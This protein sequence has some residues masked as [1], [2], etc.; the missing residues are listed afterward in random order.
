MSHA[1]EV[2]RILA[3]TLEAH[4]LDA[5]TLLYRETLADF[6]QRD[7]ATGEWS[8]SANPDPSEAVVDLYGGGYGVVASQLGPG[9]SFSLRPD[10]DWREEGRVTIAVR[11]G[12]V[13]QQGGLPYPV[14]TVITEPVWYLTLPSGQVRAERV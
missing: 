9:L 2:A 11:L 13:I 3:E 5:E 7:G 10:N 4:G 12:D 1:P 6:L 8:I 14:E